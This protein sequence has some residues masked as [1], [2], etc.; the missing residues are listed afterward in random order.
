MEFLLG[1]ACVGIYTA[2]N[3]VLQSGAN[4]R[5][6][7]KDRFEE[8]AR[9]SQPRTQSLGYVDGEWVVYKD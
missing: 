6:Y 4:D 9:R 2:V 1:A 7:L 5:E 3:S 8:T